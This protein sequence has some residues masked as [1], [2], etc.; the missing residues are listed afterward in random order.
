MP[1][2]TYSAPQKNISAHYGYEIRHGG[3]PRGAEQPEGSG[4]SPGCKGRASS[5]FNSRGQSLAA[6]ST[7]RHNPS[8]TIP[9]SEW[10]TTGS[11]KTLTSFKAS[12]LLKDNSDIVKCLFVVDRTD[13]D[14]QTREDW[15][16]SDK[17]SCKEDARMVSVGNANQFNKFHEGGGVTVVL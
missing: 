9:P 16:S 1:A 15:S 4:H 3:P 12:A 13:L 17:T 5:P 14:R 8:L 11:G 2:A 7:Q 6:A 10:S